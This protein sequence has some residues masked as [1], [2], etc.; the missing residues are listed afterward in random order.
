MWRKGLSFLSNFGGLH[1]V[2]TNRTWYYFLVHTFTHIDFTNQIPRY[3]KVDKN[4]IRLRNL[5]AIGSNF[6]SQYMVQL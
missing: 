3:S 1:V 4:F 2:G 6:D 5:H